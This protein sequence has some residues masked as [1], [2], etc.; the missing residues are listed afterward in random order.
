MTQASGDLDPTRVQPH[1]LTPLLLLLP[2]RLPSSSFLLL[3]GLLLLQGLLHAIPTASHPLFPVV[4]VLPRSGSGNSL[5]TKHPLTLG[6]SPYGLSVPRTS[7]GVWCPLVERPCLRATVPS[8][9]GMFAD[10]MN[11]HS[12]T[13][14]DECSGLVGAP[15]SEH[16]LVTV[17]SEPC[18]CL[19]R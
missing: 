2:A 10:R 15:N 16:N 9:S 18:L 3:G 7:D 1:S 17:C 4:S 13:I 11:K 19:R 8:C 6:R 5:L 14:Q 12:T